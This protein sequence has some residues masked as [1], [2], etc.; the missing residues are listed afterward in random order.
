MDLL[1]I[2]NY[3]NNLIYVVLSIFKDD[4][5]TKSYSLIIKG[6]AHYFYFFL[7]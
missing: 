1:R 7:D 2:A 5:F 6:K 4:S 3:F